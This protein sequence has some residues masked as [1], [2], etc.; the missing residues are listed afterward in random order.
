MGVRFEAE[1]R[2]RGSEEEIAAA[3]VVVVAIGRLRERW[4]RWSEV[5][6]RW[7]EVEVEVELEVEVVEELGFEG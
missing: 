5:V 1:K 7:S 2:S 4:S 6:G 3:K